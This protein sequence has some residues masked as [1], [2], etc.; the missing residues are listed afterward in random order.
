M[1]FKESTGYCATCN[2]QVLVRRETTND[3]LYAILT[4]FSCGLWGIV[5]IIS[6]FSEKPWLCTVC[7]RQAALGDYS[8]RQRQQQSDAHYRQLHESQRANYLVGGVESD[9]I[10][11]RFC[12]QVISVTATECDRCGGGTPY[13]IALADEQGAREFLRGFL[14]AAD[15]G[16]DALSQLRH[17]GKTKG[18]DGNGLPRPIDSDGLQRRVFGQGVHDRTRQAFGGV[19]LRWG[20]GYGS[21]GHRFRTFLN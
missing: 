11:C 19:G 8:Y 6:S 1:P 21:R 4:I 20:I 16:G 14:S 5:W 17:I 15:G 10:Q 2:K 9:T 13:G 18:G 3:V 12:G 7:G